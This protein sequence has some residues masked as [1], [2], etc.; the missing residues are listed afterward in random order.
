MNRLN[1][2]PNKSTTATKFDDSTLML[3]NQQ[4]SYVYAD[5]MGM[6]PGYIHR[7]TAKY[8]IDGT[9]WIRITCNVR[10]GYYLH[11]TLGIAIVYSYTII[12]KLLY[13][14]YHRIYD[15]TLKHRIP[16][17]ILW[18]S[19]SIILFVVYSNHHYNMSIYGWA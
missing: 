4:I 7:Y 16:W 9:L 2:R 13:L 5:I 19:T 12:N 14:L 10:L 3:N 1:T 6:Y 15:W 17:Q 8:M 18:W 11:V